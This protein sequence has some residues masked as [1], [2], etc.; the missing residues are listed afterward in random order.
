VIALVASGVGLV[1][2]G[3]TL[4]VLGS[5]VGWFVLGVAVVPLAVAEWVSYGLSHLSPTSGTG[6]DDLAES[7]MLA[8][9]AATP[10][11][12]QLAEAAMQTTSAQFFAVRF[13]S[14]RRFSAI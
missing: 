12:Q 11:A 14:R 8:H 4:L 2:L 6:F 13:V 1:L 5:A 9:I 7:E 10:T 3:M